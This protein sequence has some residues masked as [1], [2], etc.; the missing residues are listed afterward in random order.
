MALDRRASRLEIRFSLPI[1]SIFAQAVLHK[2]FVRPKSD[3]LLGNVVPHLHW[4]VIPR[5]RGDPRFPNPIWGAPL[6][7]PGAAQPDL[8][9]FK[10]ALAKR[11]CRL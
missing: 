5:F 1:T 3:K 6:R 4:H 9:P 2:E 7:Q 11:L 10:K 8:A